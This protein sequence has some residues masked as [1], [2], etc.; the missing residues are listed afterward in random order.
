MTLDFKM[1]SWVT[2]VTVGAFVLSAVTGVLIFFHLS[3]GLV[4]V[5]HEWLSWLLVAAV[6]LHLILHWRS[7]QRYFSR[8]PAVVLM[9]LFALI[10]LGSMLPINGGKSQDGDPRKLSRQL[11]GATERSELREMAAVLDVSSEQLLDRLQ[12]RGI[13]VNADT[14]TVTEV[15]QANGIETR[16]VLGTM[17]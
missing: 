17:F 1:Q 2:P 12:A 6:G 8:K 4:H 9:A 7:F 11:M 5:V 14:Q 15:A 3:P 10:T 16:K 13:K